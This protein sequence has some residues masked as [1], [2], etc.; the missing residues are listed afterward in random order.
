MCGVATG[1]VKPAPCYG[2]AMHTR[3]EDIGQLVVVPPG[4]LRNPVNSSSN[5]HPLAG[6]HADPPAADCVGMSNLERISNAVVVIEDQKIAW[7][8]P[9]A[10]APSRHQADTIISAHGGTVTPGLIDCHTHAVFA[11]SRENEFVQRIGG[12]TYLE[13]MEAGGGIRSTMRAVRAAT[14]EQLVDASEPR[15]R[16]MLEWGVTTV[17]IKSGYGLSPD[18]EL[19]MLRA[20]AGLRRRLPMEIVATYLAAHTIP[21]EFEG[22]PDAYLDTVTGDALLSQIKREGLAEFA[23]A[24]CERGAFTIEQSRRFLAACARHGLVPK[25]HADQITNTRATCLAVELNAASA[26]HLECVDD[27]S[28]AALASGNTVPVVLPGCSFFLNCERAPARRLIDAGLPVAIA[29][30]CN[31]GS[32]MIESL[33]LV[34]SMACTML[35]MTPAEALVA[36]TANAAAALRRA[37]RIGAFAAG[38]Q[39]DLLILD[40]SCLEK[41]AYQVGVNPVRA[42]IRQGR[43]VFNR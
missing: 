28:I 33:P 17:E 31:P 7:F 16:R 32:S 26:D 29:T 24:F 4:P 37:D 5:G 2:C 36:C 38:H 20:I 1:I 40:L 39:A 3:I 22:Q 30:D 34:M 6:C 13:I 27:A 9:A 23:D 18:D 41:W 14:V 25:L 10:K 43:R 21:P 12:A 19:K 42:V 8:G 15:L 11:G 35:R